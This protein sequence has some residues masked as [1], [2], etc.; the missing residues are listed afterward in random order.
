MY[1][2][3]P[4]IKES[5]V[6]LV[7]GTV[8]LAMLAAPGAGF[9][10]RVRRIMIGVNRNAG[11]GITDVTI[12]SHTG[13]LVYESQL[14][15]QL[16]GVPSNGY[17][18]GFPGLQFPVNEGIDASWISSAATGNARCILHYYIDRVG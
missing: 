8:V 5:S 17:E 4:L 3:P 9:A 10:Y 14:G 13:L 18:Y 15:M 2:I 12:I 1:T 7:A 11:A 16:T 6:A